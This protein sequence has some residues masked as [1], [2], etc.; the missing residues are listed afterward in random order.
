M[1]VFYL[2]FAIGSCSL[3]LLLHV[4]HLYFSLALSIASVVSESSFLLSVSMVLHLYHPLSL[5]QRHLFN[6][7]FISDVTLLMLQIHRNL[8]IHEYI[9][10]SH[11]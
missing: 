8:E 6:F 11:S 9:T 4:N 2:L 10:K 5:E 1:Q 7:G 3:Y